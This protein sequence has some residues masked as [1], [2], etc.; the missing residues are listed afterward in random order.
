MKERIVRNRGSHALRNCRRLLLFGPR[1]NYGEL[2]ASISRHE[3]AISYQRLKMVRDR[4]QY[5]VAG[6]MAECIIVLL[7]MV[8]VQEE[9]GHGPIELPLE[10]RLQPLL[11]G[12]V[13]RESG[14][15]IGRR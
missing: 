13:V 5:E 4:L 2:F 6:R 8:H 7:E 10:L 3:I 9:H 1:Q 12:S 15:R 14:H 11:K